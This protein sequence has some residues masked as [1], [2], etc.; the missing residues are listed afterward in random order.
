MVQEGKRI[1]NIKISNEIIFRSI[2]RLIDK[3]SHGESLTDLESFTCWL[4][5]ILTPAHLGTSAVNGA[6]ATGARNSGRIFSSTVRT[7]A[8]VLN[9]TTFSLD[10]IMMIIGLSNLVKKAQDNQLTTLDILQFSLSVFFF[11]HTLIQPK[12]AAGII[13]IAQNEHFDA[14]KNSMKDPQAQEAFQK[15]VD[16]NCGNGDITTKSKII[17][18]INRINDPDAFFKGVGDMNLD[19]GGRKGRTVWINYNNGQSHRINPNRY[20]ILFCINMTDCLCF[21]LEFSLMHRVM[22]Q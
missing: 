17:R 6:L 5:I 18:T 12:T 16:Q 21:Y 11:G 19:L 3:G 7:A 15:F 1:Q 14:Y 8:T 2:D 10:S 20:T 9:I 22:Q 13:D 4:S